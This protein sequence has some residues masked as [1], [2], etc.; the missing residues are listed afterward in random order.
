[1]KNECMR[2]RSVDLVQLKAILE[3]IIEDLADVAD[4]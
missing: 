2:C 3:Q 1:M 4:N